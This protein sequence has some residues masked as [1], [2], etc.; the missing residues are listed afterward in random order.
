MVYTSCTFSCPVPIACPTAAQCTSTVLY[1][2]CMSPGQDEAPPN[3]VTFTVTVI[4][5]PHGHNTRQPTNRR[6]ASSPT[7][8]LSAFSS[9]LSSTTTLYISYCI[10]PY[11]SPAPC[12]RAVIL[13][14]RHKSPG[15]RTRT[16]RSKSFKPSRGPARCQTRRYAGH[17]LTPSCTSR[18]RRASIYVH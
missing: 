3:T 1:S 13:A 2:Y 8:P 5:P 10:P 9:R 12:P 4:T 11:P 6:P 16:T 18:L 14:A 15:A 7:A 17:T